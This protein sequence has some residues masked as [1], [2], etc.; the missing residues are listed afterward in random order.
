MPI[1]EGLT[2]IALAALVGAIAV[3]LI[4][5]RRDRQAA[6]AAAEKPFAAATEGLTA[7]PAC[8][9]PNLPDESTCLYCGAEMPRHHDGT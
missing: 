8:G 7:C 6:A 2:V 4:L 9:G 3:A 1:P 5:W